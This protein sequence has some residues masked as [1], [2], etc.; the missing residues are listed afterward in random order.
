[1]RYPNPTRILPLYLQTLSF[2][3]SQIPGNAAQRL[4][5]RCRYASQKRVQ[6]TSAQNTYFHFRLN[7]I[8]DPV[9]LF[10]SVSTLRTISTSESMTAFVS[11]VIGLSFRFHYSSPKHPHLK[12]EISERILFQKHQKLYRRQRYSSRMTSTRGVSNNCK[13]SQLTSYP[14]PYPPIEPYREG[15][16]EVSKIHK[17]YYE[18]SGNPEGL[19]ICF[20]HGGPGGG[21]SPAHRSFFDPAG[22]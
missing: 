18:I 8:N 7:Q 11:R 4:R 17:V 6:Y 12:G 10:L 22:K 15:Y 1:M 14:F 5:V 20:I 3:L 16:L 13:N 19:P 9:P 2:E 21:T